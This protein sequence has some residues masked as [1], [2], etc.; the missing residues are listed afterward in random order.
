MKYKKYVWIDYDTYKKIEISIIKKN[1]QTLDSNAMDNLINA[2]NILDI[3]S[4]LRKNEK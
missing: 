4:I 2:F 3:N 1:N